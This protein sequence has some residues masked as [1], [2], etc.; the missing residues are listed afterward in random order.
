MNE[1][2]GGVIFRPPLK[3]TMSTDTTD[4]VTWHE[5]VP[6]MI[7]EFRPKR[8]AE[9]GVWRGELS[10]KILT[11]CPS[12]E[13]LLLVD[14][15]E[16]VYGRSPGDGHWLVFGPGTSN[17]EMADAYQA[18]QQVA[19]EHC[20]RATVVKAPSVKAAAEIPNGSLD[21]VLIDALHTYHACKEDILAW[22]PKLR[23]GGLMIGDDHS[24][25][26]PGVQTAVEEIFGTQ[27]SVL[28][29]TWWVFPNGGQ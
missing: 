26:F 21:C 11:M 22:M 28:G 24:E 29:Q 2:G 4:T 27:H 16:V 17:E 25:F 12:V 10:E 14:A 1:V 13:S 9:I 20:K 5:I 15:W 23:P 6:R 8:V 7:N 18:A 3:G 19:A